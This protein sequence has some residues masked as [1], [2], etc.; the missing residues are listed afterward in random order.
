MDYADVVAAMIDVEASPATPIPTTSPEPARRL[1]DAI[2]PIAMH[3]VWSAGTNTA[4]AE[5]GLDFMTGYVWG[6]SAA[7]GDPSP[8]VV[9]ATF[10]VFEPEMIGAVH[11]R[12]RATCGRE[13]LLGARDAATTASLAEILEGEDVAGTAEVL[14]RAVLEADGTGRALF[15]GLLDRPWPDEPVGVLWRA[16]EMLREH[17][18]DSHVAVCTAEGLGPVEMNLLTELW[19]GFPLGTYSASRGWSAEEIAATAED[20]R[21]IGLL[22]GDGL[23][24]EGRVFRNDIEAATDELELPIVEAIG[25]ADEVIIGRLDSWSRRCVEAKAFPPDPF[26][27]AAG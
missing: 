19:V 10:A 24:D 3:P 16:C 1:R 11:E 26:K 27:R 12:A 2:E 7:L 20:L 15:S 8:G 18:G 17:R 13:E 6:R 25:T 5:L 22:D 14:R 9:A 23:S 21:E 4:L